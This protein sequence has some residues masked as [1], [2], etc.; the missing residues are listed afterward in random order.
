MLDPV[1]SPVGAASLDC[2]VDRSDADA[3]APAAVPRASVAGDA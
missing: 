1:D 2:P 3:E